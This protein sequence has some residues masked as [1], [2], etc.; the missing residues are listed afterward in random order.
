MIAIV[1]TMSRTSWRSFFFIPESRH[2]QCSVFV[3]LLVCKSVQLFV[4][5]P[6]L[7][8]WLFE[9][10]I[11]FYSYNFHHFYSSH[12]FFLFFRCSHNEISNMLC[13]FGQKNLHGGEFKLSRVFPMAHRYGVGFTPCKGTFTE[14]SHRFPTQIPL[15]IVPHK[16]KLWEDCVF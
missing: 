6:R 8:A 7:T 14:A 4:H 12:Q 3:F 15:Y 5:G 10:D 2:L 13:V 11:C 9:F 16:T 1:G